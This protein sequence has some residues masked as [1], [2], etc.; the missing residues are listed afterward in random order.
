MA[1]QAESDLGGCDGGESVPVGP[2]TLAGLGGLIEAIPAG[3]G[4]PSISALPDLAARLI[5]GCTSL[6]A[7]EARALPAAEAISLVEKCL[8]E[9]DMGDL[10]RR[11]R[12]AVRL[13]SGAISDAGERS[14]R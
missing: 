12:R 5:A 6:D 7:A 8:A 3:A 10:V 9:N 2:L 14:S 1:E 4:R 13:A 11:A